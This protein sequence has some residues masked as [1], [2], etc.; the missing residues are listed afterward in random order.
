M[1]TGVS[2]SRLPLTWHPAT[3][4][5][6]DNNWITSSNNSILFCAVVLLSTLVIATNPN[7]HGSARPIYITV[8]KS[9]ISGH[10]MSSLWWSVLTRQLNRLEKYIG[11]LFSSNWFAA[12]T[13]RNVWA[14]NM[15]ACLAG[16]STN[17]GPPPARSP[18]VRDC[19]LRPR[20]HGPGCMGPTT[21]LVLL[22]SVQRSLF[23][24]T[25]DFGDIN[26]IHSLNPFLFDLILNFQ[27]K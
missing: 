4:K 11:L 20:L 3:D 19:A 8:W 14:D 21:S 13:G 18:A 26:S 22:F 12:T 24:Q 7:R 6:A 27:P 17:W 9:W 16:A 25:G 1:Q 23:D 15:I 5:P 10:R 2:K